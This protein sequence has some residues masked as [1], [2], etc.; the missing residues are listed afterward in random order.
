MAGQ[1]VCLIIH[2]SADILGCL[3]FLAIVNNVVVNTVVQISKSGLCWFPVAHF[4]KC[5]WH[6]VTCLT[7]HGSFSLLS[8]P[9]EVD[10]IVVVIIIPLFFLKKL[11]LKSSVEVTLLA[12][13]MGNL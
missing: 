11:S 4:E 1:V 12:G 3:H 8:K 13:S 7:Y 10:I 5:V 6:C 9:H 2:S